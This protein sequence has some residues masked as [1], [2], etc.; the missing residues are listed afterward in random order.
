[1]TVHSLD[2]EIR[3]LYAGPLDAFVGARQALAKRLKE[4][5]DT[6]E[7]E[8]RGLRKPSVSAWAVNDLFARQP[9]EVA[10]L[11]GAGERARTVQR[12]APAGGDGKPLR[13]WIAA[14]RAA[15]P[16]LVAL[17]SQAL[18]AT[19]RAPGE[20]IVERLRNNLE[21]LALDS[22]QSAIA[23][24]RWLDE[25]LPRPGFEVMAA[26]QLAASTPAAHRPED[27]RATG[28][29]PERRER[30]EQLRS[31]LTFAERASAERAKAAAVAAETLE[32]AEREAADASQRAADARAR[33]AEARRAAS[34]AEQAATRARAA[35]ERFE[36]E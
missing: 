16:R 33:A 17:G 5:G 23:A 22:A 6:R 2:D 10:A 30:I 28:K 25:D 18:A 32:R 34:D 14:V 8:V 35:L 26:L 9:H 3:A 7:A 36:G 19:G 13:E 12:P 21:A 1:M 29:D 27:A 31:E 24:R 15:L 20:A 4:A 11:L